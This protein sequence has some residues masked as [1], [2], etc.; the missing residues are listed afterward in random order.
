MI[1]LQIQTSFRFEKQLNSLQSVKFIS[2][3]KYFVFLILFLIQFI[4]FKTYGQTECAHDFSIDYYKNN[5]P[6]F[7]TLMSNRVNFMN[8]WISTHTNANGYVEALNTINQGTNVIPVMVH[9]VRATAA[10]DPS[11]PF[12]TEDQV[13]SQINALNAYFGGVGINNVNS[14]IQFCLVKNNANNAG[15]WNSLEPGI[16]RY[17]ANPLANNLLTPAS[18][19]ALATGTNTCPY[20]EV[21]NIWG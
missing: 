8:Q 2:R 5:L 21:L 7:N 13:H 4:G 10:N 15:N 11:E 19:N 9:I 6:N 12:I 14:Q 16:L 1:N 3:I 18:A 20:D 17:D